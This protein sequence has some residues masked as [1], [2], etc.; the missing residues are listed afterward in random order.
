[1]E[2]TGTSVSSVRIP[3]DEEHA[4]PIAAGCMHVRI[5]HEPRPG[6]CRATLHFLLQDGRAL[7]FSLMEPEFQELRR[8]LNSPETSA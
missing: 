5:E 6:Q 1:M 4:I 3:D 2:K 7:V 8:K